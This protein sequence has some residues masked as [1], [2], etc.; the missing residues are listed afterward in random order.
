MELHIGPLSIEVY[1]P[2]WLYLRVGRFEYYRHT[3][4]RA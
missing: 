1:L 2:G 3:L 4:P